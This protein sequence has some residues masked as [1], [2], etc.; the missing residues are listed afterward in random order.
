MFYTVC[1]VGYH[2]TSVAS[3]VA[4]GYTSR[5]GAPKGVN[6]VWIK[7]GHGE[8]KDSIEIGWETVEGEGILY[9]IYRSASNDSTLVELASEISVN[10]TF[11][12]YKDDGGKAKLNQNV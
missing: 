7:E 6:N 5:P 2:D 11:G 3:S 4:M 1:S 12:T 10:E 9:N 8:N